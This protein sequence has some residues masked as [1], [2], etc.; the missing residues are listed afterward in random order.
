MDTFINLQVADVTRSRAFFSALGFE[1]NENFT[2]DTTMGMQISD[3]SFVMMLHPDRFAGFLPGRTPAGP[4]TSEALIALGLEDRGKVDEMLRLAVE[5][6]GADYREP[7]EHGAMYGRSFTDLDG[8]V[9]EP[10][11]F[12]RATLARADGA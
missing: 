7:D 5:N 11:W 4:G 6:G 8:H 9:W 12:D 3:S 2:S 10:F 1:F